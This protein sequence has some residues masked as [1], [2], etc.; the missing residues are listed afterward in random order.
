MTDQEETTLPEGNVTVQVSWSTLN[1]KD[2][3]SAITGKVRCAQ[4]SLVPGI[5]FAGEVMES[6]DA[7]YKKGD[8][9]LLNG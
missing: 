4:L 2:A 9:V 7:R 1:Y 6:S 8:K 3:F 5:D